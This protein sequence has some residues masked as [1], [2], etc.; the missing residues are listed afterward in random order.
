M[1]VIKD[2]VEKMS[3]KSTALRTHFTP[4][5]PETEGISLQSLS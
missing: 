5:L 1:M 2:G 4:E 3:H